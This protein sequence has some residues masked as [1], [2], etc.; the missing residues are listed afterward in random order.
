MSVTASRHRHVDASP[1]DVWDVL[2]DFGALARWAPDVDHSCLLRDGELDTGLARRVQVGRNA[3]VETV[4]AIE[5]GRRLAYRI[6]GLPPVLRHVANEWVLEP[7][8]AGTEVSITSTVDAGP[9]PPQRLIARL[10]AVRFARASES[11]LAGLTAA[12]TSGGP[13]A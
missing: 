8:G 4:A 5:P 3:L 12:L 6:E 13:R 1:E 11:L 9:R 2:A 7:R 10:A